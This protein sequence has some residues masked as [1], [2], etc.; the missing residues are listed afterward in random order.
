M[1]NEATTLT[2]EFIK[3]DKKR[4]SD[5]QNA[6]YEKDIDDDEKS[7]FSDVGRKRTSI[8]SDVG[9]KKSYQRGRPGI[10]LPEGRDRVRWESKSYWK[11]MTIA[12]WGEDF[13]FRTYWERGL[14]KTNINLALQYH[15]DRG[16]DYEKAFS[17]EPEDTGIIERF[18]ESG[19]GIVGDMPTF[20][21]AAIA[22]GA[23][24]GPVGGAFA[25]A[26]VNEAIKTMYLEALDRGDVDT[27][28][29]FWDIFIS[30]GI[31]QGW[32]AGATLAATF[33]APG[34]GKAFGMPINFFTKTS[35]QVATFNA[36]GYALHG[37]VPTKESFI[38]D[39]LLFSAFNINGNGAMMARRLGIKDGEVG[40]S[41]IEKIL[42][43]IF[44]R[45]AVYSLNS[46]LDQTGDIIYGGPKKKVLTFLDKTI[47]KITKEHRVD[48]DKLNLDSG[49]A[50]MLK[51]V[52][53]GKTTKSLEERAKTTYRSFLDQIVDKLHPSKEVV[54]EIELYMK[55]KGEP[56]GPLNPYEIHRSLVGMFQRAS[57]F[58]EDGTLSFHTLTVNGKGLNA[59]VS[60]LVKDKVKATGIV[61]K[62]LN[63]KEKL[64][65]KPLLEQVEN[66]TKFDAYRIA[67]RLIEK[68]EIA[69][70]PL[71][72]GTTD[73][74]VEG[75]TSA[76][77]RAARETIK[78]HKHLYEEIYQEL[79][80]YHRR[81]LDYLQDAGII[82][83]EGRKIIEA[84]N[85]D[86]VPFN[87]VPESGYRSLKRWKGDKFETLMQNP[88]ESTYRNTLHYVMIA[89]RN[90]ANALFFEPLL[91]DSKLREQLGVELVGKQA[92]IELTKK[93]ME[94]ILNPELKFGIKGNKVEAGVEALFK[95][96][97][98]FPE[99]NKNEPTQKIHYYKNGERITFEVDKRLGRSLSQIN[100]IGTDIAI[101]LFSPFAKSLRLGATLTPEF[102]FANVIRDGFSTT[103]VSKNWYIV[104]FHASTIGFIE[105]FKNYVSV[106]KGLGKTDL[107]RK[108]VISGGGQSNFLEMNKNYLDPKMITEFQA[109][110]AYN[111][112]PKNKIRGFLNVIKR[113]GSAGE[114]AARLGEFKTTYNK[115]HKLKLTDPKYAK[116]SERQI[117]ERAGFEARDLIDF[118]KA[119][120]IAEYYN[121][122]SAFFNAR[123]RGYDKIIQ[124]FK[125]RPIKTSAGYFMWITAP[126]VFLWWVNHDDPAYQALSRWE[127][128]LFWNIPYKKGSSEQVFFKIPKPWEPGL[129]FGTS[130]EYLLD[131]IW[132]EDSEAI[133]DFFVDQFLHHMRTGIITPPTFFQPILDVTTNFTWF[134]GAP[135]VP[136]SKKH[137]LPEF[138][139]AKNSSELSLH[140]SK[141]LPFD[142]APIEV[143]HFINSWTG[144]LGRNI[145]KVTSA[146]LRGIDSD[147]DVVD[148]WSDDWIK[149]VNDIPIV[150][151]FIVRN[152]KMTSDHI[153]KFYKNVKEF[154]QYNATVKQLEKEFKFIDAAELRR[155][156]EYLMYETMNKYAITIADLKG[157]LETI[158][159]APKE[160][161]SKNEKR[162]QIDRV[163]RLIL[164]VAEHANKLIKTHKKDIKQRLK[165][166][167][168]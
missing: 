31:S 161:I 100:S 120:Y 143:D 154:R 132:L 117:L 30:E 35:A 126:S 14:G 78:K 139:M 151:A 54:R 37:Q 20:L 157:M 50:K 19:V 9:R 95:E 163:L 51:G 142:L 24:L 99:F 114:T 145:V 102:F 90:R 7:I 44:K 28:E 72:K 127:K 48:L 16:Y 83:A 57:I 160:R 68:Y 62:L 118:S 17:E 87:T 119:G 110:E 22:V 108:Y 6:L 98:I 56:L 1:A 124:A 113:I 153:T 138:R 159:Y 41:A 79:R 97:G 136:E 34:I 82:S 46:K 27:F 64:V 2:E 144:G 125:E 47:E 106:K 156:P 134:T 18:I 29:E 137:L 140:I 39:V 49:Q 88:M 67:K 55:E 166:L 59:I 74:S 73:V 85:K 10:L 3:E 165:E 162:D 103:V 15:F 86:F 76:K 91:K 81:E 77:I 158:Y 167:E 21:P 116:M 84:A 36:M 150:K 93:E 71:F 75:F 80:E 32:R 123:I 109:R 4:Q 104:P 94:I 70:G 168:E 58:F 148:V 12:L 61:S 11:K 13:D 141:H 33:A 53:I 133:E 52:V 121:Q 69:A 65:D 5:I 135:L 112:I 96:D 89:E 26:F 38:N 149:N 155:T 60:P 66:V 115:L 8:F 40:F 146:I 107:M 105:M 43:N 164:R 111:Q 92:K 45:E 23:K 129:L 63:I 25:G 152:P 101:K 128:D 131:W 130:V 42:P 122:M 147:K